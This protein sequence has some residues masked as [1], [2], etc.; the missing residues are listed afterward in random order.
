MTEDRT[1]NDP[2]DA[3]ADAKVERMRKEFEAFML[4][5]TKKP[6]VGESIGASSSSCQHHD[7]SHSKKKKK[8]KKGKQSFGASAK[9]NGDGAGDDYAPPTMTPSGSTATTPILGQCRNSMS[10]TT[11]KKRYFQLLRSFNDKVQYNWLDTDDQMLSIIENIVSIRAR[12]P[13]EWKVLQFSTTQLYSPSTQRAMNPQ[14][15]FRDDVTNMHLD[16]GDHLWKYCGFLGKPKEVPYSLVHL[17]ID[18]IQLAL[19]NDLMQHEKMLVELRKHISQLSECHDALGRVV[20]T[21][22]HFHLECCSVVEAQED[23]PQDDADIGDD[24]D[25][26]LESNIVH[27]VTEVFHMLSMELL[28][29]QRLVPLVLESTNDE[30][31]GIKEDEAELMVRNKN[32]VQGVEGYVGGDSNDAIYDKST[33]GLRAARKCCKGWKRTSDDTCVD[34]SLI[35]HLVKLG[36]G[37]V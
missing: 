24:V 34:L 17:N 23:E 16:N 7:A 12:L 9:V 14:C 6:I 33:H 19:S 4:S 27:A 25:K 36:G 37:E 5:G 32:G 21:L 3:D 15:G 35:G 11:D 8:K 22:W 28:R 1:N 29:K 30:L 13:I 26:V 2:T 10:R 20:D 18:D 31:L